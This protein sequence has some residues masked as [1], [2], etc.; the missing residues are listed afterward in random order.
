MEIVWWIAIVIIAVPLVL[1]LLFVRR[2]FISRGGTIEVSL[3]LS[4]YVDGRGWSPGIARFVGDELHWYRVFSFAPRPR[5]IFKRRSF[6]VEQRRRP[7]SAE[8]RSLPGQTVVLSCRNERELVEIAMA[9]T[10]VTGFM[11]WL[12]AA[13]P[14]AASSRFAAR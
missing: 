9:E 14:G 7:D 3:R 8:Q 2:Q 5:R 12:E 1:I 10:T 11:S 4:S 6:V 13:P